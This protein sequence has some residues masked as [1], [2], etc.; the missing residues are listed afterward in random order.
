MLKKAKRI[1]RFAAAVEDRR[2]R[3]MSS[4]TFF[5]DNEARITISPIIAIT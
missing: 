1:S 2:S 4:F 3:G 5:N